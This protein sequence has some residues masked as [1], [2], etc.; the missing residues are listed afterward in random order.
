MN[1]FSRTFYLNE[2]Y[3]SRSFTNG[4]VGTPISDRYPYYLSTNE[5]KGVCDTIF[6]TTTNH[7]RLVTEHDDL[8]NPEGLKKII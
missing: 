7:G 6:A 4:D 1:M 3:P 2:T 5:I 8:W